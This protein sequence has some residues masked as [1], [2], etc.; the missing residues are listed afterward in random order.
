VEVRRLRAGDEALAEQVCHLFD[1]DGASDRAVDPGPFLQRPEAVMFV[2]ED[3]N[4]LCGCA[5]GHE[6]VHPDGDRTMLLY[7][8]DVAEPFRRRGFGAAL[9]NAFVDHA[10]EMGCSEVWVLTDDDNVAA[11]ATYGA[12]GG[13]RDPGCQVMFVWSLSERP[14]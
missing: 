9:V 14:D 10:R 5:Y 7:S 8:L 1:D 6:L 13:Q 11:V 4:E 2:I 12:A 3:E